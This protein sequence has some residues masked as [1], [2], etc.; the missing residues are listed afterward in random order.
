MKKLI[1]LSL[2]LIAALSLSACAAEKTTQSTLGT[3]GTL[4]SANTGDTTGTQ[5]TTGTSASTATTGNISKPL[6]PTDEEL[7]ELAD[8]ALKD[9]RAAD[10]FRSDVTCEMTMKYGKTTTTENMSMQLLAKNLKTSPEWLKKSSTDDGY[11]KQESSV[12]FKD[13]YFYASKCGLR[14]KVFA[15][16]SAKEEFGYDKTFDSFIAEIPVGN[17]ESVGIN[18]FLSSGIVKDEKVRNIVINNKSNTVLLKE[19]YEL[20]RSSFV[21][22]DEN[23]DIDVSFPEEEVSVMVDN[24]GALKHYRATVTVNVA[25]SSGGVTVNTNVKMLFSFNVKDLNGAV[26]VEAP[27]SLDLY[28]GTTEKE[29]GYTFFNLAYEDLIEK[30]DLEASS[31]CSIGVQMSGVSMTINMGGRLWANNFNTASPILR[32][33]AMMEIVGQSSAKTDFYFKNG[34][35]YI[36]T[37]D[38]EGKSTQAKLSEEEYKALY[39]APD[40]TVIRMFGSRDFESHEISANEYTG[41]TEILFAINPD[42]FKLQFAQDIDSIKT[43]VV[44]TYEVTHIEVYEPQVM[45]TLTKD[46]KLY[47]YTAYYVLEM[48]AIINGNATKIICTVNDVTTIKATEN[49]TVP[50]IPNI[51]S[52]KSPGETV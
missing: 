40:F 22:D 36:S 11:G 46:G 38:A 41:N 26:E 7:L 44:G 12:Y 5:A 18:T 16:D 21:S 30:S 42:D 4:A 32:E 8:K 47:S 17:A 49:V 39:G 28:R 50:E 29:F 43:L 27:E 25:V 6:N 35:Y 19:Y 33:T 9:F 15:S 31:S 48:T 37:M 24:N 52:F 20:I 13:G 10:S 2:A 3:I 45:A 51:S 14:G 34:Y 23:V 1:A